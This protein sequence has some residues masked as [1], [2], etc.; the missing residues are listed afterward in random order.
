MTDLSILIPARNE[1]W[2]KRTIESI[3]PKIEMDTEIIV[4]LDGYWPPEPLVVDKR[5]TIL[6]LEEPIGQRAA[7]N[8][9]AKLSTAEFVMKM[10]AHCDVDKGFD[11][12]LIEPYRN[13]ELGADVTSVPQM[14]NLHVFDWVCDL[15]GVHQD[16]GPVPLACIKRGRRGRVDPNHH[17]E[18]KAFHRE[19]IW[20]I[21]RR[22]E[23]ARFDADLH[24][25]YW[26][27][28]GARPAAQDQLA[29][30][31][32]CVGA[33]W[34]MPRARY[35]ELGGMDEAHG[36]W[37]QMGVELACKSWLSGGQQVVNKR[38][39][40]AHLFRT[41]PG[42]GFPYPNSGSAQDAARARSRDLWMNNKWPGQMHPL[43]WLL[44]K[45]W[46]VPNWD[47]PEGQEALWQVL[48]AGR[49]FEAEHG[50]PAP[51]YL[52]G[53]S[54]SGY[55]PAG[56]PWSFPGGNN[57]STP[58]EH[59]A[60]VNRV[61]PDG[62]LLPSGL[63]HAGVP[64]V[65]GRA[66]LIDLNPASIGGVYY[67][68]NRLDEGEPALALAV[69][70][71]LCRQQDL[72][73]VFV[74]LDT[75]PN[76]INSVCGPQVWMTTLERGYLTM[77]KQILRGLEE[78]HSKTV[79]LTEHDVLYHPSHFDFRPPRDDTFYYNQNLWKVDAA[80]GRTLF[81]YSNHV[82]QICASR[83]LLLEH[84]RARVARVEAE[85]KY[86]YH[87]GFEPGTHAF[88][89]GIDSHPVATWESAFP[90]LDVRHSL[91]LTKSRWNKFEF[92]NQKYTAGWTEGVIQGIA[93]WPSAA[94][95]PELLSKL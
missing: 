1:E 22:T 21:R 95:L 57:E 46:P 89:R 12:K 10:D 66:P 53:S 72:D 90:N 35:W 61:E 76:E 19:V 26:G 20:D 64:A 6:H 38:T 14:W 69:R 34:M 18:G 87:I 40:F 73:M 3:L 85:G 4:I 32:C 23:Y 13:G 37:G 28:Y 70:R 60:P 54:G 68:D 93:G 65:A 25:Q 8:L 94:T 86:D 27:E 9:A 44:D 49:Q 48:A 74:S 92:R 67:T 17:C 7:T 82:S 58:Q 15:C 52:A 55:L 47:G 41:Q 29:P 33:A 80:T 39:W 91:N 42:F 83:E 71:Q 36:S 45:F 51:A 62:D 84:Y 63:V 81:Y 31:M 16:Q 79:F 77:F 56:G 59:V 30:V 43:A 11:R 78:L 24:F 5:V 88:P 75:L 2:L 50:N